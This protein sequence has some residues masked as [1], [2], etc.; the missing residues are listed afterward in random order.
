MRI[1]LPTILMFSPDLITLTFFYIL[2]H[3]FDT[4]LISLR[5]CNQRIGFHKLIISSKSGRDK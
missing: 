5:Y 1:Y 4:Y 3:F 2:L